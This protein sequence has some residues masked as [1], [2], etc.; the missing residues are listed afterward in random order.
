M[1]IRSQN[2]RIPMS[3]ST[4]GSTAALSQQALAPTRRRS[5][6]KLKLSTIGI[7]ASAFVLLI[8]VV[9]VG[10]RPPEQSNAVASTTPTATSNSQADVNEQPTVND[11]VAANI[12]ASV[13][14]SAN[15]SVADAVANNATSL[16][17]ESSLPQAEDTAVSK[18]P[19]VELSS[20]SRNIVYYA[21]QDGDTVSSVAKK[22]NVNENTIM[23]A[24]NLTADKLKAGQ[25]LEILPTNGITYT[26]KTGDT[27]QSVADK[28]KAD[29]TL[30]TTYNDLE[31]SG[32]TTGLKIIIPNGVLPDNER[33][34]YVAP[35]T[36]TYTAYASYGTGF[37]GNTWF[38]KRGT[39]MYAGNTYA[40][41]NCTAYAYDRRTELGLPVS[42]HWGNASTWAAAAAR[43]G[44]SVSH[45]PSVGAVMQNGGGA[46][47][48]AIVEKILDN[49]DIQISEMNASVSGGGYNIVSGRTVSASSVPYY[50]YIH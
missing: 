40:F 4:Q 36:Y 13:A 14:T 42:A 26:A 21:T 5:K 34:G 37:S 43:D 27:V 8:A 15:L 50:N 33:P 19:I 24:N 22:Y 2:N 3:E 44:L 29:A 16:Q 39:P 6:R 47:H 11:V 17:I 45:S 38:I 18:P 9:A 1:I 25:N 7:Y 46:G 49:G 35:V 31:I 41:G 30:I 48:V 10:Y 23:W 20:A 12:A 32:L 28:Y